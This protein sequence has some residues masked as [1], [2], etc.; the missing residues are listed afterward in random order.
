MK[1]IWRDIKGYEGLYQASNLGRIKR[2]ARKGR[3]KDKIFKL[4][5][6]SR[7]YFYVPLRKNCETKPARVHR[8][9]L[10]AFISNPENKPQSNHKNGIK[11]DN[12]LENLEWC[13]SQENIRH[14]FE[15]GLSPMGKNHYRAELNEKQVRIIKYLKN[16][17][18]KMRQREIA[19]IF[20][21]D[22]TIISNI[23]NNKIW[24]HIAI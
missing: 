22:Q 5:K 4:S 2:L 19:K 15:I 11:T 20:K 1:E 3:I 9:V 18:P 6:D 7:G 24:K 8:L 23:W 16:I 17:K 21:D 14:A 10:E 12:G 13:T